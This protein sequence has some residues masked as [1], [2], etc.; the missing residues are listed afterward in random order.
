MKRSRRRKQHVLFQLSKNQ[1]KLFQS[2]INMLCQ[3]VKLEQRYY[4]SNTTLHINIDVDLF[5]SDFFLDKFLSILLLQ[6][7]T[8]SLVN[9]SHISFLKLHQ[10]VLSCIPIKSF[11]R[12]CRY[13]SFDKLVSNIS[14]LL[15]LFLFN[16]S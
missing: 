14:F 5:C 2:R 8:T 11:V 9:N 13:Y 10:D 3:L 7:K 15:I 16:V 6:L 12:V 1:H 4:N